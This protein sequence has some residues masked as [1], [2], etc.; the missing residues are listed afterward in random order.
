[1]RPV[2][3]R[4]DVKDSYSFITVSIIRMVE[5]KFASSSNQF[6]ILKNE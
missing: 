1:M 5:N 6:K 4:L 3:S 2:V